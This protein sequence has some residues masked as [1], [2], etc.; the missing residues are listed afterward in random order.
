MG[1]IPKSLRFQVLKRDGFK[2]R[3]CG[4]PA[5][6]GVVLHV[7]HK[8]PRCEGGSDR[9]ENLVAACADCNLGKGPHPG[10]A[11]RNPAQRKQGK[12]P[13]L[14]GSFFHSRVGGRV[15]WQGHVVAELP[16]ERCLIRLLSWLDGFPLEERIVGAEE[17]RR[18]SFYRTAE[19]MRW[20]WAQES[21]M[22]TDGNLL[23]ERAIDRRLRELRDEEA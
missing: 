22:P 21:R 17:M 10:T 11:V 18:W 15:K 2:C 3:Y 1:E 4:R 23:M 13:G 7:D 20:A 14:A 6:D 5:D 9:I 16:G 8:V 19:D 12:P